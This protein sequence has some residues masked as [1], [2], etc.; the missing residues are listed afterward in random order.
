MSFFNLNATVFT[1]LNYWA[2]CRCSILA[3]RLLP[4]TI[5]GP[6]VRWLPEFRSGLRWCFRF[7]SHAGLFVFFFGVRFVCVFVLKVAPRLLFVFVLFSFCRTVFVCRCS[8]RV[9][10]RFENRTAFCFYVCVGFVL[11][12]ADFVL[13]SFWNSRCVVVFV[14]MLVSFVCSFWNSRHGGCVMFVLVLFWTIAI[15]LRCSFRFCFRFANRT[16]FFVSF[17]FSFLKKKNVAAKPT[18]I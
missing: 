12:C 8:F 14:L 1:S 11:R 4:R 10:F 17:S 7:E 15:V 6:R 3:Q 5:I 16:A 9:C 2:P 18:V 13:C